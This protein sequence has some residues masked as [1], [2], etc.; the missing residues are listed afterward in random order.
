LN[1][2]FAVAAAPALKLN[3]PDG[4]LLDC[5]VGWPNRLGGTALVELAGAPK[6]EPAGF[7]AALLLVPKGVGADCVLPKVEPAAA[8]APKTLEAVVAG[9]PKTLGAAAAGAPKT[10]EAV[11]AG[12]PKTL[13][14]VAVGAPKTLGAVA[15]GAPKTLGAVAAGVPKTL[16]AVP[17]F[18]GCPKTE[19]V[20]GCCPNIEPVF[21][22]CPKTEAVVLLLLLAT[23]DVCPKTPAVSCFWANKFVED[24]GACP[25]TEV[26]ELELGCPKIDASLFGNAAE[27]EVAPK[28]N[29]GLEVW[30]V[31]FVLVV[32]PKLKPVLWTADFPKT[33]AVVE[34]DTAVPNTLCTDGA[35][36][37][38][39]TTGLFVVD[40]APK[41]FCDP[42]DGATKTLWVVANAPLFEDPKL[43]DGAGVCTGADAIV[44]AACTGLNENPE[45]AATG[46]GAALNILAAVKE[47]GC[48]SWFVGAATSNTLGGAWLVAIEPNVGIVGAALTVAAGGAA[49][50]LVVAVLKRDGAA[51]VVGA[52]LPKTLA[53]GGTVDGVMKLDGIEVVAVEA[54]SATAK[55]FVGAL[56]VVEGIAPNENW[57]AALEIAGW[58]VVWTVEN[59]DAMVGGA[60]LEVSGNVGNLKP[61]PVEEVLLV[62]KLKPP[63]V[64]R[65]VAVV[66][67]TDDDTGAGWALNENPPVGAALLF[68]DT[69]NPVGAA[70]EVG[71]FELRF[72]ALNENPAVEMGA[73]EEGLAL[74]PVPLS[75]VP[76]EENPVE[77]TLEEEAA[78]EGKSNVTFLGD[79]LGSAA[80]LIASLVTAV[81][82]VVVVVVIVMGIAVDDATDDA[83]TVKLKP[84]GGLV[85]VAVAAACR[86]V[87]MDGVPVETNEE[88]DVFGADVTI[89]KNW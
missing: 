55:M 66:I 57:G 70:V 87:K 33:E 7:P 49:N 27:F 72:E 77:V 2:G 44:E 71:T 36:K 24:A 16:G 30:A 53:G 32:A 54:E 76:N 69:G 80:G 48:C 3:P 8:D 64:G 20:P 47:E 31:L 68:E 37:V 63:A 5:C 79:V 18:V 28:E 78:V 39:A 22:G 14:A 67:G 10:L 75:T 43:K 73:T 19:D 51:A 88:V 58:I 9:T 82:A 35:L 46:L 60:V 45:D 12:A 11:A 29:P 61:P 25:K 34:V 4:L 84:D 38:F 13:G 23:E 85:E 86:M 17:V 83:A 1:E 41:T 89:K 42:T 59:P 40:G 6:I 56:V 65:G 62:E 74:K 81:E 21:D 52:M 50:A 15:A 26:V